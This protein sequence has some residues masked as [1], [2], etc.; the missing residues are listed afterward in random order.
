M[1]LPRTEPQSAAVPVFPQF[2]PISIEDR[3][4]IDSFV[5]RF[6]PYSDYN[7]VSLFSWATHDTVQWST[8]SS[9]LLVRFEGYQSGKPFYSLLGLEDLPGALHDLTS[10]A[11]VEQIDPVL[12]LVPEIVV[13]Q[14]RGDLEFIAVEDPDNHDYI[15]SIAELV[16]CRAS[17]FRGKRSSINR[18]MR[19]VGSASQV[20]E[21]NLTE[22]AVWEAI[23]DVFQQWEADRGPPATET[24]TE[25]VAIKRLLQNADALH[26]SA[27]GVF[28]GGRLCAF[29]LGEVVQ[30]RY[31]MLHF[32]KA[33][34]RYTGLFEFLRQQTAIALAAQGCEYLNYQQDLGIEGIRRMKKSYHPV[35]VLR[36]YSI[37]MA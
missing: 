21:L 18:F 8:R 11:Q 37:A 2:K 22:P 14:L 30:A 16:E 25:L 19:T 4:V 31:G 6:A 13:E 1:I 23:V 29:S 17:R 3:D 10:L 27:F 20:A 32:E 15:M 34:T 33:A 28:I 5:K 35:E 24:Q 36:K 26:V 12:R 9:D 7:F